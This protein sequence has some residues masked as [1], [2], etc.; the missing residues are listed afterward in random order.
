[1]V[2]YTARESLPETKKTF[3]ELFD[4]RTSLTPDKEA[5]RYRDSNDEWQSL[6]WLEEA[7]ESEVWGAAL[8]DL[9][10]ELEHRVAIASETRMEWITATLAIARAGAA[11]TTVYASTGPS[12]VAYILADSNTHLIFV[13]N[14]RQAEKV[15]ANL[16]QLPELSKL[17]LFDGEGDG[18]LVISLA[19]F[20]AIGQAALVA[21]PSMVKERSAQVD[22][23][24]LATLIY[25]S[26]TTGTPKGVELLQEAWGFSG[27]ALAATETINEDDVQLLWLPMAHVF[28]TVLLVGQIQTGCVTAIDA[29][30]GRVMQ[31]LAE[32][33]P[34][35][36][37]A[38]PRIFEKVR[39]GILAKAKAGG[40]QN[41]LGLARAIEVG[42]AYHGQISR[43]FEPDAK[44]TTEFNQ[45]DGL[46]LSNIRAALGGN[47]RF[48]I[49]G[50][51]PLAA[52]IA[53][54][55]GAAGMPILEGYGLTETSAIATI[56]RFDTVKAGTVGEPQPGVEI[57][58]SE[59]GE[60]L[61]RGPQV[62]RGYRNRPEDSA[63]VLL[64]DGWFATGD[65]G[66]FDDRGR[67]KITDRKKDLFKTSGG[68]YV[69][70]SAIESQF[71]AIFG[72][73]SN[74]VVHANNR[75]F[76]SA[77]ITLDPDGAANWATAKGKPS[78]LASVAND[79]EMIA[80]VQA[81]IDE[82]NTRLN[83]WEQVRKF[84][85]LEHDFTVDGGELTP[86][87]KVKRKVI[88]DR[89]RELL[90]GLYV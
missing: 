32:V 87:L 66:E 2:T 12:D 55:F 90:D 69:A 14:A 31:N 45:L 34:T 23:K 85:I 30:V 25:T 51:A 29:Q 54:F 48:F 52:E 26:G 3:A 36:M 60:I 33:K 9:G 39:A 21:N 38:V 71:K 63:E 81:A 35:F 28:G 19:E 75:K 4:W 78:D 83:H 67:L 70:P 6:T 68:K 10:I 16:S 77:L 46:V 42:A 44:L 72:L 17:V 22:P 1:M 59:D 13:E 50:S 76:V 20:R 88:E 56:N 43:G 37:G 53:D 40:E 73:A 65:I 79:P 41:V 15:I 62:M 74:I 5:F 24:M 84:V 86:S 47:I 8:I 11:C 18:D 27:A 49:S 57:R 7:Q 64:A 82:L 80:A 58:I 61:V 89:N